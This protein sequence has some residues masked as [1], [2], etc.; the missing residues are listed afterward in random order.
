MIQSQLH[1]IKKP[2]RSGAAS[3][4][5]KRSVRRSR[6]RRSGALPCRNIMGNGG[7]LVVAVAPQRYCA[8]EQK[9]EKQSNSDDDR[10][11][12]TSTV[13]IPTGPAFKSCG[14]CHGRLSCESYP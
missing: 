10:S 9:S 2:R 6:K 8:E 11:F 7:C 1:G 13:V 5:A 3:L 4:I 14:L 12:V